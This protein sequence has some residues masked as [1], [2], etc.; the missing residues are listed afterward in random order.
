MKTRMFAV[1]AVLMVALMGC[2]NTQGAAALVN[3]QTIS[4]RDIAT[5]IGELGPILEHPDPSAVLGWL[6]NAKAV[7]PIAVDAGLALSDDEVV[8]FL[9]T[10][11]LLPPD[12]AAALSA[13]SRD[14]VRG[15]MQRQHLSASPQAAKYLQELHAVLASNAIV[16]NPRYGMMNPQS[17]FIVPQTPPWLVQRSR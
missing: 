6:I 7:A 9:K 13:V 16:V 17:G 10:H 12:K 11:N 5:V 15:I 4:Q 8:A 3:G 2:T 1:T 14:V